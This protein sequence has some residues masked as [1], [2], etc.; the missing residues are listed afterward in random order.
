MKKNWIT[1][2]LIGAVISSIFAEPAKI[3]LVVGN[4]AYSD[5]IPSLANP[6]NDASDISSV[7]EKNGWRVT[8]LVDANRRE[9]NRSIIAF[10]DALKGNPGSTA[11]FY[12]AG[13]GVQ[14]EGKN[15][16]LPIGEVFEAK[17]DVKLSAF[18]IDS[19]FDA[20]TE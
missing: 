1:L 10:Q 13:H 6:A 12:Y 2:L 8:K 16:M 4:A 3:A 9:F 18:C 19:I 14:I 7:L 11:L 20:F 15:Y 5:G 17:E